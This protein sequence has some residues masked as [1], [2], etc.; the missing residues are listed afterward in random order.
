M[1]EDKD[2]EVVDNLPLLNLSSKESLFLVSL[3]SDL[4]IASLKGIK[5]NLQRD[6][7]KVVKTRSNKDVRMTKEMASDMDNVYRALARDSKNKIVLAPEFAGVIKFTNAIPK[8]SP[9]TL[10]EVNALKVTFMILRAV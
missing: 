5:I 7:D 2:Y 1:A 6:E 9:M 8:L 4:D 10:E 3:P